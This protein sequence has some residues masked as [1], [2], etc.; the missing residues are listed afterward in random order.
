MAE[1]V[2]AADN[3]AHHESKQV[4]VRCTKASKVS[5]RSALRRPAKLPRS[6]TFNGYA[7]NMIVPPDD[8][9]VMVN[10]KTGRRLRA[11]KVLDGDHPTTT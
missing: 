8:L 2:A 1:V 3:D 9:S 7:P 6:T 5:G 11:A 10:P 4:R